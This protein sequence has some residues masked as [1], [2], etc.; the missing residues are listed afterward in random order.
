MKKYR[1]F[2]RNIFEV[3]DLEAENFADLIVKIAGEGK[4]MTKIIMAVEIKQVK[5]MI[6][7]NKD[8]VKII[9]R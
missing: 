6:E 5:A 8:I 3:Y 7:K 1:I 2:T 9:F 4:D